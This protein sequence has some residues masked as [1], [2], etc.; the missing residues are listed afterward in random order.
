MAP[1]HSHR[2]PR[3]SPRNLACLRALIPAAVFL[4]ET[5][6]SS[7]FAV[8]ELL[9]KCRLRSYHTRYRASLVEHKLKGGWNNNNRGTTLQHV[10]F[11]RMSIPRACKLPY[12]ASLMRVSC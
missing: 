11:L 3:L 10:Y 9:H 1:H 4:A 2:A 8:L 5:L 12:S 6:G 7:W